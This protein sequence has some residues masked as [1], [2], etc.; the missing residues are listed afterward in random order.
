MKKKTTL[1]FTML[2]SLTCLFAQ[3]TEVLS[4]SES[5]ND[6]RL[7]SNIKTLIHTQRFVFEG[8]RALAIGGSSVNIVNIA[9]YV[10]IDGVQT[11]AILPFFGEIRSG[12]GYMDSGEVR[13]S[14]NMEKYKVKFNDKK[15]RIIISFIARNSSER[16]DITLRVNKEG[17]ATLILK[18]ID[19][20]S[21]T[22]HGKISSLQIK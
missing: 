20:N 13:F 3:T 9:N 1:L 18:S 11:D 22:Y 5:K 15:S 7:Y 12:N 17:W 21:I 6:S 2:M 10:K 4:T 8:D 19:R 16:F 14:G